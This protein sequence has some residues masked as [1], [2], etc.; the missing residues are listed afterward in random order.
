MQ[1]LVTILGSTGSIGKNA[2]DV[3]AQHPD[4]FLIH[5]LTAHSSTEQLFEQCLKYQPL[6]A[7]LGS[8][9]AAMALKKKLQLSALKTEVLYGPSA[10]CEVASSSSADIVIAGIVGAAGLMPTFSAIKAGKRVLLANKEALVMAGDIMMKSALEAHAQ[11]MPIDSEHNALLQC[12]PAGYHPGYTPNGV[13]KIILTA[14]GG[15]FRKLSINELANVSP[16][17]ALCHPNWVMGPKISIDSATM[18]NKGLE[19]IE[20]YYLFKV[21]LSQIEVIVHPQSLIHALV[22]YLD[23]S[24]LA[25]L[26]YPDMRTPIAAA[27]SWPNRIQSGVKPIDLATL[28]SLDFELPDEKRFPCLNLAKEALHEGGVMPT[29]MNASNEVAVKAF[30]NHACS[31]NEI[32]T[33]I[34]RVM[35]QTQPKKAMDIETILEA[36]HLSRLQAHSII[37]SYSDI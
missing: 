29:V 2:L 12:M 17:A 26:G 15:P 27:L 30:L 19:I 6:Y 9:K 21:K 8:E 4:A 28:T 34:K 11:L 31:F 33:I 16:Q 36:D 20:A 23:G 1:K 24:V 18:M 25:Q 13:E 5:A 32:P 3:I 22:T 35:M 14:S 37:K 10:L 7:V